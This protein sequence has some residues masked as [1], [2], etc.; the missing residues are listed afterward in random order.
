MIVFWDNEEVGSSTAQ[1]AGSPFLP[2]TLER[3][4][5]S[6]GLGREDYLQLIQHSFCL[7]I[8]LSHAIH[9]NY[10]EKHEPRHPIL[11]EGGIVIKTSAQNRYATDAT[12]SAQII[13]L[14]K[15]HKIPYQ[16]YVPRGDIP[17]GTTIGPIHAQ[18]TGMPTV[19]IGCAQ[20]SMHA[21]REIAS[22]QDHISMCTL[23][24]AFFKQ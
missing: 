24:G 19:D 11:L 12:A 20:L 21:I 10:E 17:S 2:Q 1:G 22:C 9:P 8:D 14:C 4:C 15:K 13:A 18:L 16:M 5:L 7:S 23:T 6:L 3:C